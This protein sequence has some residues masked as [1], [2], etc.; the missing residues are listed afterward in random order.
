MAETT[1][2]QTPEESVGRWLKEIKACRTREADFRKDGQR[3]LD[4]YDGTKA[5][6]TPFNILFSNTE[7]L[8]PALYS[9]TPRPDVQRRFK[10]DDPLGKASSEAG[11][12][13]LEFLIDTNMDQYETFD[14]AMDNAVSCALLPGRGAT[15][16]KYEGDEDDGYKTETVCPDSKPWNRVYYGYATKWNKVPWVAYEEYI[17][18][19]EA[20]RQ[21]GQEMA[22]LLTFSDQEEMEGSD[23]TKGK[24]EEPH[25]GER[26]VCRIYQ[27]WDKDG[28]RMVRYVSEQVKD[29]YLKE[30]DDPLELS[31]FFNCPKPLMFLKKPHTLTPTAL[32][33]LYESQAKELNELTRRIKAVTK[34]IKAKGLYDG[35]LGADLQ[36]LVDAGEGE[37]VP[38][39]KSSSLAAEKGMTNAI[40]FFPVEKLIVVVRE[41]YAARE[42]CKQVI[43]E[44]TGISDIIRGASK[45]SET[46]GAQ[47]IKTQWGTLRLKRAQKEVARY[48]RDILRIMLEIA[49]TKFSQETWAKMTGL[50]FLVD[51]KYN[52][53]TKIAQLLTAQVQQMAQQMPPP[54]PGQPPQAPP[55]QVQQLQQVKQ[56][57]EHPKWA[58]VLTLLRDD[59]QRAYRID[60]ET[61]STVEPEAAEDQKG[62]QEVLA[63]MA[64]VLNGIGPLVAKGVLPFEAA[65]VM[66]L[67]IVR[68]FRFGAELEDTIKAM[69]P[70]KP[71]D[72][73]KAQELAAMQQ[74]MAQQQMQAQQQTAS[75]DLQVK[76]MTAE[77][78]ILEQKVDLQLREI[79]LKAETDKLA[80]ERQD[81]EK[82][83]GLQQQ[84]DSAKI[85]PEAQALERSKQQQER[86]TEAMKAKIQQETE[87][88]KANIVKETAIEVAKINAQAQKDRP[89][90]VPA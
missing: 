74:Q 9:A 79:Q 63:A 32:Y 21:F 83:R 76:S 17:D 86:A 71:E 72:D 89:K 44:I 25:Q 66:L 54:Q 37:L 73:G 24:K 55:P 60:I 33:I 90:A 42:A 80:L 84:V 62:I 50:P 19:P 7:T 88:A 26:K 78:A 53:L 27:I 35:E 65:Q 52:E 48:A 57:L 87:L 5:A 68:R 81:F 69:Q 8:L 4:L 22:D 15:V 11:K 47:E 75:Q 36:K 41:L 6:E 61:N 49:A 20:E 29:R 14:A 40:W 45:A 51:A 12:R 10:D 56:Q 28:G 2:T 85:G 38:A 30:E 43:Y 70:P 13:C 67:T 31:G 3:I 58:D 1:E 77:K 82:M 23:D 46:L 16:V 18:K 39:D 64:Q 59:L 34:A